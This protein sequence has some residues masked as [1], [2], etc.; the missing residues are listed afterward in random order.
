M[1][2]TRTR[3]ATP[4]VHQ[5]AAT[6][7]ETV[8]TIPHLLVTMTTTSAGT[9]ITIIATTRVLAAQT[10]TQARLAVTAKAG[11]TTTAV[12]LWRYYCPCD[13]RRHLRFVLA[14]SDY[15][16]LRQKEKCRQCCY[17][18]RY[19]WEH[20]YSFFSHVRIVEYWLFISLLCLNLLL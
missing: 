12:R 18:G 9:I 1:V 20:H 17:D 13:C 3:T 7:M 10:V 4:R 11:V 8:R 16:M 15:C 2:I 19:F 6:I 5:G 14:Y